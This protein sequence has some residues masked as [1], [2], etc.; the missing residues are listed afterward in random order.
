[1]VSVK[2]KMS[3][4]R[5]TY[6]NLKQN[7]E[8][9]HVDLNLIEEPREVAQMKVATYQQKITKY[10]NKNVRYRTFIKGDLV[11]KKI[12]INTKEVRVKVL[13]PNWEESYKITPVLCL[14]HTSLKIW[15]ESSCV[16]YG[17]QKIY[18][19]ITNKVLN[20]LIS[21]YVYYFPKANSLFIISKQFKTSVV[22]RLHFSC[23]IFKSMKF[24]YDSIRKL[25]V[26]QL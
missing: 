9:M 11:L 17:T 1:M 13:Y 19:N 21:F 14:V 12:M 3:S 26:I 24:S 2:V 22:Q 7:Q 16:T 10:Y 8:N 5:K 23:I 18:T 4:Q 25:A 6:F 20:I 15:M